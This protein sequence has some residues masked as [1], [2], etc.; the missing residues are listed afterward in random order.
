MIGSESIESIS[1]KHFELLDELKRS[2]ITGQIAK[3]NELSKMTSKMNE[4]DLDLVFTEE[5]FNKIDQMI[6]EKKISIEN[7]CLL[8]KQMGYCK[9]L[10]TNWNNSYVFSSLSLRIERMIFDEDKKKEEKN[11]NLLVDLSE[12][13]LFLTNGLSKELL[14]ICIPC[15][16]KIALKKEENEE[17]QKEVEMALLALSNAGYREVRNSLFVD[18]IKEIIQYHQNH[19]NL[20]HLAYQS[21][22]KFLK[23]RFYSSRKLINDLMNSLHF[24]EEATK[25]LDELSKNMNWKK[26][27]KDENEMKVIWTIRRWFSLIYSY[28]YRGEFRGKQQTRV[29]SCILRINKA[30]KDDCDEISINWLDLFR[31]MLTNGTVGVSELWRCGVGNF[32]LDEIIKSTLKF[33]GLCYCLQF[34][35]TLSKCMRKIKN[36]SDEKS[37]AIEIKREIFEML[38]EEDYED[39][40]VTFYGY[41]PF[42]SDYGRDFSG[43]ITDFLVNV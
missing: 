27:D 43:Q 23:D 1:E 8:L 41:F 39:V 2:V 18:K 19:R 37:K 32:V 12:C 21:A 26:K 14:L 3:I 31:A 35:H 40:I 33:S 16:L 29:I 24:I 4:K 7:M 38:E 25:E 42:I 13:Y 20:T 22:W 30:A 10:K 11:V 34:F 6:E 15:L 17:A 36:I 9:I 28:F 5:T